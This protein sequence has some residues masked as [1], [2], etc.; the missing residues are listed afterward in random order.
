MKKKR[1]IV[2]SLVGLLALF[3]CLNIVVVKRKVAHR[4]A[5][6]ELGMTQSDVIDVAGEPQ[7]KTTAKYYRNSGGQKVHTGNKT[8]FGYYFSYVWDYLLLFPLN[9][10]RSVM[11]VFGLDNRVEEVE[12]RSYLSRSWNVRKTRQSNQR[13]EDIP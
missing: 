6:V 2:L 7:D 10:S 3:V 5:V 9:H 1:A 8:H 13:V 12:T 4:L 11:V